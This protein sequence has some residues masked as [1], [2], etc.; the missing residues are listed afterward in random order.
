MNTNKTRNSAFS[1]LTWLLLTGFLSLASLGAAVEDEQKFPVFQVGTQT[2]TNVTVTS[3]S[4]QCVVITH[5][6]GMAN[7][8]VSALT[9]EQRQQLGLQSTEDKAKISGAIA[10]NWVKEKVAALDVPQVA[11][12]QKQIE[13][14]LPR[15]QSDRKLLLMVVAVALLLY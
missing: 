9:P 2:Y 13:Q 15:L 14:T 7:I 10:A 6:T 5:S 4:K 3:K 11:A 8:K 1:S 12:A